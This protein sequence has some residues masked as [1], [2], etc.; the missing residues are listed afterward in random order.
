MMLS[1]LYLHR[2]SASTQTSFHLEADGCVAR[3]SA[4]TCRNSSTRRDRARA[5]SHVERI[6]RSNSECLGSRWA[7][8][9]WCKDL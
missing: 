4:C 1:A 8:S 2:E 5:S 9:A 6:P 7:E 3:R